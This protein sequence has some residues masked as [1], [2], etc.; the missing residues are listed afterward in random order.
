[1]LQRLRFVPLIVLAACASD[2]PSDPEPVASSPGPVAVA[3]SN[4][5]LNA[6]TICFQTP[7]G[8]PNPRADDVRITSTT[9]SEIPG[10]VATIE[11]GPGQPTG[12]LSTSLVQTTTPVR[13][14][15]QATTGSMP[16][17]AWWADVKISAPTGGD[18]RV[19]RVH[20][21][22][23]PAATA[24]VDVEIT[25]FLDFDVSPGSGTVTG[26]GFNCS[27][28]SGSVCSRR[29]PIGTVLTLTATP[30]PLNFFQG[31]RTPD[32]DQL[33]SHECVV[34][35]RG[36]LAIKAGFAL[37]PYQTTVTVLGPGADGSILIDSPNFTN[38]CILNAGVQSGT[39]SV[40]QFF[41]DRKTFVSAHA[42]AGSVFVGFSG[43]CTGTS[44]FCTLAPRPGGSYFVTAT[45]A[46]Q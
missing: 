6:D 35:V 41:G 10:V 28:L 24:Q 9:G 34:T 1:M 30:D 37:Q 46:K 21:T 25:A 44:D 13:L 16:E 14:W 43:D 3:S 26:N 39:C 32:C 23:L 5:E 11:Y 2:P 7:V 38:E 15:L 20:F 19:L 29:F 18:A 40:I 4:L 8:G 45:F 22:V 27:L 31:W 17:G 36:D 33:Q 42:F 12:W